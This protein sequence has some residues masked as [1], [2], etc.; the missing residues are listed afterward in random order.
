MS[1]QTFV[2]FAIHVSIGSGKPEGRLGSYVALNQGDVRKLS[3][4]AAPIQDPALANVTRVRQLGEALFSALFQDKVLDQFRY[5]QGRCAGEKGLRLLLD[6]PHD[7]QKLPWECLWDPW[8]KEFLAKRDDVSI[9]RVVS[10]VP[11]LTLSRLDV[12]FL[13]SATPTAPPVTD[14]PFEVEV[15]RLKKSMESLIQARLLTPAFELAKKGALRDAISRRPEILHFI[16]HASLEEIDGQETPGIYLIDEDDELEF[17]SVTELEDQYLAQAR[18]N[19]P[20]LVVLSACQTAEVPRTAEYNSLAHHLARRVS[21]VLAQQFP[22]AP[23][24]ASVFNRTFYSE[25][26]KH[27]QLE[28]AVDRARRS[29]SGIEGAPLRDWFAP[30]LIGGSLRVRPPCPFKGAQHYT[31]MDRT[32][33]FG[34]AEDVARFE[35]LVQ[36]N[37]VVLLE[38]QAGCGKT[39][40]LHA[41]FI[42]NCR[43]PYAYILAGSDLEVTLRREINTLLG[44]LEPA[45][46]LDPVTP[47]QNQLGRLPPDLVIIIDSAET[48]EFADMAAH[49]LVQALAR[50]VRMRD[51][52]EK[53]ARLILT[54]RPHASGFLQDLVSNAQTMRLEMLDSQNIGLMI[55]Q[56]VRYTPVHFTTDAVAKILRDLDYEA[57]PNMLAVQVVCAALYNHVVAIKDRSTADVQVTTATIDACG[58]IPTIL[59]NQLTITSK[60]AHD[61]Y[62]SGN[63]ARQI[64][65]QLVDGRGNAITSSRALLQTR[66]MAQTDKSSAMT[67]TIARLV[68]DGLVQYMPDP[69]GQSA[70][71]RFRLVHD[72]L[73]EQVNWLTPADK[74][75]RGLEEMVASAVWLLPLQGQQPGLEK[76]PALEHLLDH[77]SI[78]QTL[79]FLPTQQMVLLHSALEA[80]L[81]SLE[82][83]KQQLVWNQRQPPADGPWRPGATAAYLRDHWFT[84]IDQPAVR[85]AALTDRRLSPDARIRSIP[86]LAKLLVHNL[87]DDGARNVLWRMALSPDAPRERDAAC[88][89]LAHVQP[90]TGLETYVKDLDSDPAVDALARIHDAGGELRQYL[91]R[92][93]RHRVWQALL[94]LTSLEWIPAVAKATTFAATGLALMV[95]LNRVLS[96]MH[97]RDPFYG[98]TT[99][100][101]LVLS[102]LLT[103]LLAAPGALLAGLTSNL[104]LLLAGGRRLRFLALGSWA[105][106]ILHLGLSLFILSV[107]IQQPVI[108]SR[109]LMQHTL[110]GLLWGIMVGL[111]WLWTVIRERNK[112]AVRTTA[113]V[114]ALL[115][116]AFVAAAAYVTTQADYGNDWWPASS[117][118]LTPDFWWYGL[119]TGGIA[120]FLVT[121]GLCRAAILSKTPAEFTNLPS[122]RAYDKE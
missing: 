13:V 71:D 52:A 53:C 61:F 93:R 98:L 30:V 35:Q 2:D 101:G 95:L 5:E 60:L 116:A 44:P 122:G 55:A 74:V 51:S 33:F 6:L 63:M 82:K 106:T 15:A 12:T 88:M 40:L 48:L 57:N 111:P 100:L 68:D 9:V 54:S 37:E 62:R 26:Q 3:S 109:R 69:T 115:G 119:F 39:S 34:R 120:S 64:L 78:A 72:T 46:S 77:W 103:L 45:P 47:L 19:N 65:A 87:M 49:E 79:R 81:D 11:T 50:W 38:G 66:V 28:L 112:P 23:E 43:T 104:A 4:L 76:D 20:L 83:T 59:R 90:A 58:G 21:S 16:G 96:M 10:N 91:T 29:I 89:A 73:A 99:I 97:N 117:Y 94:R 24:S 32:H 86:L 56:T 107:V 17:V 18:E 118:Y 7:L 92:A 113:S 31:A 42:S 36:Q 110:T 108:N 1:I 75:Q 114:A 14:S 22:I 105:G 41:G 80:D 8:Q 102:G 27:S 85:L 84:Q 25:L 70:Y 67:E 121:Y